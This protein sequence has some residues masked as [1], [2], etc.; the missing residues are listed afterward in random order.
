[1]MT[2]SALAIRAAC[3]GVG[4]NECGEAPGGRIVLT[5]ALLPATRFTM[6]W[7]GWMLTTT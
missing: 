2:K 3:D 5:V 6:S 4:S 1:M 7:Y